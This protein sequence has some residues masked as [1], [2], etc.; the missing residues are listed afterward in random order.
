MCECVDVLIRGTGPA[1]TVAATWLAKAGYTVAIVSRKDS[2]NV[3]RIEAIGPDIV[4]LLAQI[5]LDKGWL[6]EVAQTVPGTVSRWAGPWEEG[7]DYILSPHGPAW[8]TRRAVF[9]MALLEHARAQQG[10][11]LVHKDV[12]SDEELIAIGS[13]SAPKGKLNDKLIA[14]TRMYEHCPDGDRRLRIE[15]VPNGWWYALRTSGALGL[16]FVTD[17]QTLKS[18]SPE[19]LW[20]KSSVGPI[21]DLVE[22]ASGAGQLRRVP[23]RCSIV[24]DGENRIGNARA[25]YDP[26]TGRGVAEAVRNALE[27]VSLLRKDRLAARRRLEKHYAEYLV[28][29]QQLYELGAARFGTGFWIRRLAHNIVDNERNARRNPSR[30]NKPMRVKT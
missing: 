26:L 2:K 5:G 9:D 11:R 10:V 28:E 6:Q 13:D 20:S 3:D 23:V 18:C 1:G 16:G 25:A 19:E 7:Q 30:L 21:L 27:T 17:R 14:L 29:R 15:A 8:S 12:A 24:N 4:S 22:S